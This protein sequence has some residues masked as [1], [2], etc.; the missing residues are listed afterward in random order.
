MKTTEAQQ[1][2]GKSVHGCRGSRVR[3]LRASQGRGS[4]NVQAAKSG[5]AE[6]C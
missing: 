1:G 5:Q 4:F 2:D 6:T 3:T